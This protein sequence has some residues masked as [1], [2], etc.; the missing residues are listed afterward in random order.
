M[1]RP[2]YIVTESPERGFHTRYLLLTDKFAVARAE[3]LSW[4][5]QHTSDPDQIF[6]QM[7]P[8]ALAWKCLESGRG[9]RP[10]LR[11]DGYGVCW[12]ELVVSSVERVDLG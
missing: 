6:D 3:Q 2:I 12:T 5:H 4:F 10:T 7:T 1:I 9:G 11:V 8:F